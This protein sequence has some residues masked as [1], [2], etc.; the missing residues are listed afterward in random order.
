MNGYYAVLLLVHCLN[1]HF[2]MFV[3]VEVEVEL[4]L[5]VEV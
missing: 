1:K 5:E 3:D 4:E 2:K